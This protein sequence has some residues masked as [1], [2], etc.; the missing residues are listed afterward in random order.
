MIQKLPP[1]DPE[2]PI[3]VVDIGNTTTHVGTWAAGKLLAPLPVPTH[4][5]KAFEKV[6]HEHV[7][8][9]PRKKPAAV[10]AAC[11]APEALTKIQDFVG[12]QIDMD[13]LV[14]GDTI[15][16]PIDISVKDNHTLG[17]DRACAAAATYER[18]KHACVVVDFGTAITVDLIDDD[19]TLLGGAILPGV[20]LQL[21]ALHQYTAQLPLVEA[22]I[23]ALPYGRDTTEAI[24]TG[25]CRGAVGA[26]RGIIEGYASA[27]NSWPQTVA[28]GGD[29]ALLSPYCDFFDTQ[30]SDLT[31]Y[32]VGV[33]Y[34]KY[35]ADLGV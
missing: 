25:V 19:G 22:A 26:V 34:Q 27:L 10:V 7:L 4:D 1:F 8:A 28:T 30:V 15:P 33:A 3:L 16:L 32:G 21:K 23:P 29:L 31:L 12:Q 18:L 14:V 9:M 2:A 20:A 13:V 11:V 17:V 6:Y 24:Q 5:Q 35:L